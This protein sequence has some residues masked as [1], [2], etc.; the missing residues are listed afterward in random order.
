M[1]AT[2]NQEARTEISEISPLAEMVKNAVFT[3]G[4]I[5]VVLNYE[6]YIFITTMG[7]ML[8]QHNLFCKSKLT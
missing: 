1:A 5:M 2:A 7:E 3:I 4:E 8:T 6:I